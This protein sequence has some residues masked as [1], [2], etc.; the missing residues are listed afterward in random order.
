MIVARHDPYQALR[1]RSY[2]FLL[3]GGVTASLT[4]T[5]QTVAVAY[6]LYERTGSLWVLG[7]SG[8]VQFLPILLFALPAGM[9][10]DHFPRKSQFQLAQVF[11]ALCSLGLAWL[12][13]VQADANWMLTL[14]FFVGAARAATAPARTALLPQVVSLDAL[15]NAV[16]WNSSGWQFANIAGPS[17][18]GL[19]IAIAPPMVTY[20]VASG[21]AIGCV[22]LL[23]GVHA[24]VARSVKQGPSVGGLFEGL[25]FVFSTPLMLAAITLDLFAVLL[26]GATALLP[27]FARDVLGATPLGYGALR[28]APAVGAVIMAFILA[29]RPPMQRPGRAMMLAVVAFGVATIVF[30]TSTN[31][32]LSIA[33]LFLLG[34]FD[35]ISV[36]VRH[37]LVQTIT[38]DEMRGRVSA[39]NTVFISSSNELGEFES[40]VT[41]EWFGAVVSVVIGGVG[42]ILVVGLVGLFAPSL[43]RLGP[44]AELKSKDPPPEPVISSEVS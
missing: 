27:Y 39:V 23:M 30:G 21:G 18:G 35:N 17:V 9:A 41:A 31:Y 12:S 2:V 42:T 38:P 44:L 36:V 19:L 33:C 4:G 43:W 8:L 16:A 29:H 5:A 15:P 10:A 13:S 6:E 26:G 3:A 1:N 7:L 37:T 14:L 28:A 11:A 24:N 22:L 34:A 20:L 32:W 25:S 40:G